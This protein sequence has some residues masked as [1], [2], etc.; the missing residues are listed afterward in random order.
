M[1]TGEAVK[2]LVNFFGTH[3][4]DVWALPFTFCASNLIWYSVLSFTKKHD[5]RLCKTSCALAY[6]IS[7]IVGVMIIIRPD[8]E[9]GISNDGN[10]MENYNRF[11]GLMY[12]VFE[13][14]AVVWLII[15]KPC[16]FQW[17]DAIY[18]FPSVLMVL[19]F[20]G[21]VSWIFDENWTQMLHSDYY[22]FILPESM[23]YTPLFTVGVICCDFA[24]FVV[25]F[26]L[27]MCLYKWVIPYIS[28]QIQKY[29]WID[30][31]TRRIK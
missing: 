19:I 8:S 2:Q 9:F 20:M 31:L 24:V 22:L 21:G 6:A 14:F 12:H 11:W 4:F 23:F 15:W 5:T 27:G 17:K 29:H 26:S 30:K 18:I 3:P 13:V 10:V 25:G 7:I 28:K 16:K 1:L